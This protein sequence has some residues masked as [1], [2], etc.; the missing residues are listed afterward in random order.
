MTPFCIASSSVSHSLIETGILWS[1]SLTKKPESMAGASERG[2]AGERGLW[3]RFRAL[4]D[5]ENAVVEVQRVGCP[6]EFVGRQNRVIARVPAVEPVDQRLAVFKKGSFAAIHAVGLDVRVELLERRDLLRH[7]V[8]AVVDQDVDMRH[9]PAHLGKEPAVALVADEY[10]R[11]FILEAAAARIDVDAHDA[12]PRTEIVV[13]HLQG[14]SVEDADFHDDRRAAPESGE[15]PVVDLEVVVPLVY[16]APRIVEEVLGERI[17]PG[18]LRFRSRRCPLFRRQLTQHIREEPAQHSTRIPRH[19]DETFKKVDVLLVLE[20]RPVEGR[21]NGLAVPAPER[22]GRDVLGEQE[23]QPVEELGGR[24]LFL[25]ARDFAHLEERFERFA[26]E[27]LLQ[28]GEVHPDDFLHRFLVGKADVVEEAA[29]QEGVG[30]LLFVVRGDEH[31]RAL[32]GFDQLLRLVDEELHAVEL[33]QQVVRKLDVGLVDLVDEEHDRRLGGEGLPQH[34]AHYVVADLV[35]ARV[36]ELG[37]AQAAHR[38]V[39]VQA[40]LRLGGGLDVPFEQRQP[41]RLRHFHREHGLAGPGLAFYQQRALQRNGRVD[42][43]RQVVGGNVGGGSVEAHLSNPVSGKRPF[44]TLSLLA[45]SARLLQNRPVRPAILVLLA[46]ACAPA[47][48]RTTVAIDVGHFLEEPGATSA[49]GRTEL[50]FNRELALEIESAAR[51]R[52]LGTMLIGSDGFMSKLAGRTAAAAGAAFFLSVHHDSVPP[53]F[54]ETWEY[55]RVERLFSDRYAGFSLF[56][57][58]KSAFVRPSL[59]CASAIGEAVRRAGF[60]P[61]LYH[62]D[63]IPA[64]SK[65]FADRTNGV[66]YY[67]NLVV[68]KTARAPAVL[69]EAGVIVNRGEELK[70]QSEDVRRRI[71]AAVAEGLERCLVRK[72]AARRS[73]IPG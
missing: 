18:Q 42:R 56:V 34:S 47:Q 40:L 27:R 49:R 10:R 29:P 31:D 36:A 2:R 43:E 63:P 22:L 41:E 65:P 48:A 58:R 51:G 68:L 15:V 17:F 46:A 4:L 60:S 26:Q 7:R 9:A 5:H 25:Q 37:V 1:L 72:N 73:L 12:G 6:G 67:D 32:L 20:Q 62:A 14:S 3:R 53:H 24:G 16:Q 23:L 64:V 30:Q 35:H 13:P 33:A 38:V 8:S 66:H 39:L 61:S 28:P 11:G 45:A 19:E 69:L 44:Y 55:D 71:A 70:V 52:G 54:L 57:S 59:A 21:D 50:E